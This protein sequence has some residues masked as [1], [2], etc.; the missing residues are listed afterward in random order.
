LTVSCQIWLGSI[1]ILKKNILKV[2]LNW[3]GGAPILRKSILK[4]RLS[5]PRFLL[6]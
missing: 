6:L 4:V 1:L 2:E 5:W 3:P